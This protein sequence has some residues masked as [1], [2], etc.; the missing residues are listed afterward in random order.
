MVENSQEH[1]S[2][3][4]VQPPLP[5][6]DLPDSEIFQKTGRKAR[7]QNHC[8]QM[9]LHWDIMHLMY[10]LHQ[11][12][13]SQQEKTLESQ[14]RSI[15]TNFTCKDTISTWI[16]GLPVENVELLTLLLFSR[17][18]NWKQLKYVKF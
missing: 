4:S 1:S 6:L 2:S 16:S 14:P 17:V 8:A 12:N 7:L 3:N 11:C 5:T 13:A 10:K 15:V 18:M 9:V